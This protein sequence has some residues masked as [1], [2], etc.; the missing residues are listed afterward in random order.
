MAC[1]WFRSWHGAP[2]DPKWRTVAKRAGVRPG[3]VTALVWL[4]LD[5]ASQADERGSIAGYDAEVLADAL[6]YEPSDVT[7]IISALHDKG[8][9]V[10]SVFSGWEKYQPKREDQSAERTREW[11]NRRAA[12][13][14]KPEIRE[15]NQ[16]NRDAIERSVTHGDAT[17][18]NVTLDTD[19][20]TD[21]GR[22]KDISLPSEARPK[23][24]R[25]PKSRKAYPDDFETF[26]KA[27]PTDPNQSK[28]EA[29][30]AWQRLGDDDRQQAIASVPGFL[31]FC[32]KDPT[33]RPIHACRYLTKRRFEGHSTGPPVQTLVYTLPPLK[34][35]TDAEIEAQML[36][37]EADE[38][39]RRNSDE[40]SSGSVDMRQVAS[41]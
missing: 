40:L 27:Y 11:R 41:A 37:A 17:E 21:I 13:S 18:H 34:I 16:Q 28:A 31:A 10:N 6:G 4:L 29:L 19:T 26:W 23:P 35:L 20:D 39:A 32:A 30:T 15:E 14:G 33:Y 8:V 5:R 7:G 22:K 38:D 12:N 25:T 3:D 24:V 9:L 36:Q 2:T 1:E